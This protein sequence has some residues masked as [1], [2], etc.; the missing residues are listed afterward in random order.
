MDY[1]NRADGYL[2]RLL[3][4]TYQP[5]DSLVNVGIGSLRASEA[6]VSGFRE[7]YRNVMSGAGMFSIYLGSNDIS[8]AVDTGETIWANVKL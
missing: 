2:N 4:R 8:D 7:Y 1:C 6:A 5:F 3:I